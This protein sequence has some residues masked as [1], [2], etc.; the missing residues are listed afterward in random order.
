MKIMLQME[1]RVNHSRLA[2]LDRWDPNLKLWLADRN[3]TKLAIYDIGKANFTWE[4]MHN[5]FIVDIYEN[6][7]LI[8]ILKLYVFSIESFT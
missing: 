6:S 2:I 7:V 8:E 5:I 4:V 3:L 1:L